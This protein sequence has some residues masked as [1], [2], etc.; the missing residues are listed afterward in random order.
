MALWRSRV[1]IPLG[2]LEKIGSDPETAEE[3]PWAVLLSLAA[4][5][6]VGLLP[7]RYE[8]ASQSITY[9]QEAAHTRISRSVMILP[10]GSGPPGVPNAIA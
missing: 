1:G 9:V 3:L 4:P 6:G 2:P 10:P 8:D 7:L 5:T